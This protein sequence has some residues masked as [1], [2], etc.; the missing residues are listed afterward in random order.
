MLISQYIKKDKI[1][2]MCFYSFYGII[3]KKV[4]MKMKN[5]KTLKKYSGFFLLGIA[6]ILFNKYVSFKLLYRIFEIFFP[7]ILG[8]VLAYFLHPLVRGLEKYFIKKGGF[9]NQHNRGLSVFVVY[10]CFITLTVTILTIIIPACY[11]AVLSLLANAEEYITSYETMV[12]TI[13]SEAARN[14]LMECEHKVI[15]TLENFSSVDPKIYLSTILDAGSKLMSIILG[16]VFCPY[17]LLERRKLVALFDKVCGIW[18]NQD[19][20][21]NIHRIIHDCDEIFGK[22]V[23][24][25]FLDSVIIGAIALIGLGLLHIPYYP[26][27]ALIILVT[28]MV[29]YFGP[30]IGGVP[31]AI[32]ALITKGPVSFILVSLFILILQQFDGLLLGPAILGD[33]VGI[34][35]FWILASITVFGNM[36]GFIGMFLAVPIICMARKLLNDYIEYAKKNQN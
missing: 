30:F 1:I 18:L 36:F 23:Y 35:P 19:I 6:L 33:T 20:I 34:S 5:Y 15:S 16:L 11:N 10:L 9:L 17:L 24:G 14:I 29:P 12:Q 25:K 31:I 21:R 32:F 2:L 8:T 22:F 28:N 4:G 27:M 26:F 13:R 3:L 7:I